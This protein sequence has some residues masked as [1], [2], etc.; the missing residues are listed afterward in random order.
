MKNKIKIN[1]MKRKWIVTITELEDKEGKIY[2]VTRRMPELFVSETKFFRNK[3]SAITQ[4]QE[5]L[6]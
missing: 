5:W 4:F 2:K 6:N 3:Q 1:Y